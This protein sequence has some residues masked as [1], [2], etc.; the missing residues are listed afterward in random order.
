MSVKS[1]ASAAGR[2][3]GVALIIVLWLTVLLTVIGGAF[4]YAMRTDALAARNAVSLAQARAVADG[5]VE[6]TTY[7]LLRPRLPMSWKPDGSERRFTDNDFSV[8][9]VTRDESAN[10]DLNGAAEPLLKGLLMN[11][12]GLDDAQASALV[13]AIV[14]WRDPDELRRP[15]GA[16]APEYRAANSNYTPANARFET[17]GEVSRVLGMTPAIY[18]RIAG[19]LSVHSR[20]SGLN[21]LTA[22]R[23]ALLALPAATPELVDDYIARR[24]EALAQNLPPPPFPPAQGFL[25]GAGPIW[26]VRAEA[27]APDGVTFVREAVVRATADPRRPFYA[28]LWSEGE[29]APLPKS[30]STA[31]QAATPSVPVASDARRS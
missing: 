15:N 29:R 31:S 18:A 24:S 27:T 1:E 23:D 25:A 20:Q 22:S 3:A 17:V 19:V 26:R 21:A 30:G 16:E 2:E 12:G 6:R 8:V 10:I 28:L 7:E 13:D 5:V 14:D 4:A 11:V 9:V